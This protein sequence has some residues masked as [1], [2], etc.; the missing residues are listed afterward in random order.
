M[1][2][3]DGVSPSPKGEAEPAQPPVNP[4]LQSNEIKKQ[5][6]FTAAD[7]KPL[8]LLEHCSTFSQLIKKSSLSNSF[9]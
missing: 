7:Y 9:Y 4:P 2:V 5:T 6:S 1:T 8:R 3:S